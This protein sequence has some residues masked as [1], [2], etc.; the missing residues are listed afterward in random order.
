MVTSTKSDFS[1][2]DGS[3]A[4]DDYRKRILIVESEVE[5]AD[6]LGNLLEELGYNVGMASDAKTALLHLTEFGPNLVL[7][8]TYLSDMPGYELTQ[9]LRGAPQYSIRFRHIG[10]L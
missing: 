4:K 7:L 9:I 2:T 10:L 5:V 1:T 8:G 6:Q 3:A